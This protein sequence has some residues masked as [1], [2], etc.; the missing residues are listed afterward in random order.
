M[1]RKHN[2][3]DKKN[4]QHFSKEEQAFLIAAAEI[5]AKNESFAEKEKSFQEVCDRYNGREK[6]F[7]LTEAMKIF[8]ETDDLAV[9]LEALKLI[10]AHAI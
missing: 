10:A 6:K 3:T 9:K 5:K 2:K 4:R 8:C 1:S 7:I